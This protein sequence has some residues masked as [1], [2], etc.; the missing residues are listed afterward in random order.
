MSASILPV[1]NVAQVPFGNLPFRA[2]RYDLDVAHKIQ[3]KEWSG[4]VKAFIDDLQSRRRARLVLLVEAVGG[5]VSAVERLGKSQSQLSQL[6]NGKKQIGETLARD[7]EFAAGKPFG[8]L[9]IDESQEK[10]AERGPKHPQDPAAKKLWNLWPNL[11]DD[12]R[13]DLVIMAVNAYGELQ[14]KQDSAEKIRHRA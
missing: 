2:H 14:R 4:P 3:D 5:Q 8:W 6:T 13:M 1:G 12:I 10:P 11:D 9:D 7:I